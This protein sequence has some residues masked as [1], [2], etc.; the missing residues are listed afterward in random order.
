MIQELLSKVVDESEPLTGE[1]QRIKTFVGS[2]LVT[3]E[4]LLW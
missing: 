1:G 3:W 2:L 4:L